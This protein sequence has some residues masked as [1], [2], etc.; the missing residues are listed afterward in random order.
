VLAGNSASIGMLRRA[1]FRREAMGG[2]L[3]EYALA[4]DTPPLGSARSALGPRS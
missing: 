1:G 2:S 4:L 3:W